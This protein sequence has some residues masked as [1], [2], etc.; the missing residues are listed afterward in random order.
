MTA[1]FSSV[2]HPKDMDHKEIWINQTLNSFE[3]IKRAKAAPDL[4]M[5]VAKAVSYPQQQ[6]GKIRTSYYWSVAAGIAILITLN[7]FGM[8]YYN[9]RQQINAPEV[10]VSV[11]TDYLSYLEPIKL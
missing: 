2:K 9:S 7:I 5:L 6:K 1:G 8:I 4:Y 11:A 10:T 3:G